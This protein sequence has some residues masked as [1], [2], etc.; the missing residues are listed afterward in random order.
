MIQ[1]CRLLELADLVDDVAQPTGDVQIGFGQGGGQV[2]LWDG[3]MWGRLP[4]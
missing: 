4:G 3:R 2:V 1:P